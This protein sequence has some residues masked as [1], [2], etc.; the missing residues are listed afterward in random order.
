MRSIEFA[1]FSDLKWPL[2]A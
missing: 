1:I 2:R